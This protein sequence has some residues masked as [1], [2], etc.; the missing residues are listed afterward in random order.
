MGLACA[1]IKAMNER[2][3]EEEVE[4]QLANFAPQLPMAELMNGGIIKVPGANGIFNPNSLLDP[5]WLRGKMAPEE[6]REAINYINR[7]ATHAHVGLTK[8]HLIT[9]LTHRQNLLIEAASAAVEEIKTR[10][11]SVQFTFQAT[12]TNMQ[13]NMGDN[14]DPTIQ[15]VQRL[16]R[17]GPQVG[18]ARFVVLYIAFP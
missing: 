6:Y 8:A 11:P 16:A 9:E 12:A 13:M 4:I 3:T 15:N 10:F 18:N 5:S 17:H 7:R 2:Y 1:T 14:P